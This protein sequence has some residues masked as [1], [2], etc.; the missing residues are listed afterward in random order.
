MS[1][2]QPRKPAGT[3]IGGQW[4]PAEHAEADIE[5]KATKSL[6]KPRGFPAKALEWRRAVDLQSGDLVLVHGQP[7]RVRKVSFHP[8]GSHN[9][10]PIRRDWDVHHIVTDYSHLDL[11]TGPGST[12]NV[13]HPELD[14]QAEAPGTGAAT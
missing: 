8:A 9:L 1:T 4:A 3:P 2:N 11:W 5:L 14:V 7:S 12:V 10:A 13:Y 6:P